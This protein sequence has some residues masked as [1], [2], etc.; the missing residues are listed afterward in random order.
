MNLYRELDR[1]TQPTAATRIR[2]LSP[3]EVGELQQRG[4]FTPIERIRTRG[5]RV[6]VPFR[7]R[8]FW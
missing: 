1:M 2:I 7:R 3:E 5:P 8:R 6:S 4:A